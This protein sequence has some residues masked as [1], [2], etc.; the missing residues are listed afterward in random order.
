MIRLRT[1]VRVMP[2]FWLAIP[3]SIFAGW[4]ATFLYPSDGYAVGA[5]AAGTGTLPFVGPFCAACAAWEGSRLRRARLWAAPSVRSRLTIAFWCLLPAVMVGLVAVLAAIA[6]ELVRAG[7]GLPDLRL[8]A[9][10][11]LDLVALSVAGF[12][13]GL[14]L[15]FAVA[16]PLAIVASFVWLVFVPAIQPVWLRHLTGMFRD[17][18]GLGQDLAPRAVVASSIVDLGIIGAAALLVAGPALTRR[19]VGGALAT[20][21]VAGVAGV[22]LVGGMAYAPAVPRDTALLEC[23]TDSGVSVCTWPEHHARAAEVARIVGRVHAG[24]QRAGMAAPSLFTEADPTVAPA[25][26]L[27]FGFIGVSYTEDDIISA[28]A[29]GMLPAEPD[30]PDASPTGGIAFMDLNAWYAEAGG[31]T[32]DEL[33]KRYGH[34]G[35]PGYPEPLAVVDQLRAATPDIRRAWVSRAEQVSQA[36]GDWPLDLITV[37]R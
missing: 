30:C 11:A 31:M 10:T 36:C 6:V 4:Y 28:L 27:V 23:R 20:L 35:L 7:T 13:A 26:A 29:T 25:G 22:L 18:C 24:W 37:Q 3:I 32:P 12:A 5:T 17:C 34:A 15:P 16:G 14:L 21:A 19:R 8:I 33:R 2:A 9:M 1:A